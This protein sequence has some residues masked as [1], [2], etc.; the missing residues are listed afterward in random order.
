MSI[1]DQK[2]LQSDLA[3]DAMVDD[4][5][6]NI[7]NG[8][9]TVGQR[10]ASEIKLKEKYGIS[11]TS[12]KRGLN[13]LVE[14]GV[15]SRKRGSGTYVADNKVTKPQILV[16]RDTVAVFSVWERWR[17]HPFFSEQYS[18]VLAGLAR[19][20]WKVLDLTTGKKQ[21]A[22]HDRE[23]K[24]HH[25]SP[26]LLKNKLSQH[27]EIA[28]VIAL[29]C[30]D[31]LVNSLDKDNYTVIS[32][33]PNM[34]LSSISYDWNFEFERLFRVV[35]E[36]GARNLCIITSTSRQV[37]DK[38]CQKALNAAGIERDSISCTYLQCSTTNY[39]SH[40]QSEA[41]QHT[42]TTFKSKNDFDGLIIT[43]DF[44]AIGAVDA[45]SE[46]PAQV[47]KKL[48]VAALLNKETKL[49]AMI[50]MTALVADGY[51]YGNMLSDLI[52]EQI[53]T[54]NQN[55]KQITLSCYQAEHL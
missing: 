48:H 6:A 1:D 37:L 26:G 29:N 18:G 51:A 34:Q 47:R 8:H 13:T 4:I 54:G 2:H 9:L 49:P 11:V 42:L 46:L 36:K 17:Y 38:T 50:P 53:S 41:Y 32:T 7:A 35:L 40:I 25:I 15:L 23:L 14:R 33:G 55:N 19:N 44:G 12:I 27:P 16:Q 43:D 22:I 5:L 31:E 24:Y 3:Y 28:G 45:L 52:H 10:I 39:S 20:G 21:S 30:G